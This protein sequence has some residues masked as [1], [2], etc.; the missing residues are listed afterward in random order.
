MRQREEIPADQPLA[1]FVIVTSLVF[2]FHID[3]KKVT[4]FA[5]DP[6]SRLE[7]WKPESRRQG[8]PRKQ[9][10]GGLVDDTQRR[11]LESTLKSTSAT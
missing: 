7:N 3:Y 6:V 8:Q 10:R 9:T 11:M 5:G 1:G 2:H 4:C